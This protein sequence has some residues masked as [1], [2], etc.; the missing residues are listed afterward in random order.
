MRILQD[1]RE[2]D[3]PILPIPGGSFASRVPLTPRHDFGPTQLSMLTPHMFSS[4]IYFEPQDKQSAIY[5]FEH[6]VLLLVNYRSL[7]YCTQRTG[8]YR[9]PKPG[10]RVKLAA[11]QR[12]R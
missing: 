6:R 3:P 1:Q 11:K 7:I 10:L 4:A 9:I 12:P 5:K 2:A 8:K